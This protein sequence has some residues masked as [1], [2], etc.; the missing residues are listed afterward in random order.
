MALEALKS[1]NSAASIQSIFRTVGVN[2]MKRKEKREADRLRRWTQGCF[3]SERE[4]PLPLFSTLSPLSPFPVR[5]KAPVMSWPKT[6]SDSVSRR[7][8]CVSHHQIFGQKWLEDGGETH[9]YLPLTFD[10]PY[11]P[12]CGYGRFYQNPNSNLLHWVNSRTQDATKANLKENSL[13]F[14]SSP[15]KKIKNKNQETLN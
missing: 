13:A 4:S 9:L 2:A 6:P 7:L 5:L 3:S 1:P 10:L 15:A 14:C 11:P 8:D 12:L